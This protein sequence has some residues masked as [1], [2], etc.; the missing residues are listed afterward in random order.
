MKV[1]IRGVCRS[2][3]PV[4]TS[5]NFHVVGMSAPVA[6]R[7][8]GITV[9]LGYMRRLGRVTPMFGTFFDKARFMRL[10]EF[11]RRLIRKTL[12]PLYEDEVMTFV[13]WLASRNS[14]NNKQKVDL[15]AALFSYPYMMHP[16]AFKL[17]QGIFGKAESLP[18][19]D[20]KPVRVICDSNAY[21]KG[22]C[23][24]AVSS[25]EHLVYL[26]DGVVKKTPVIQ[27]AQLMRELSRAEGS[28]NFTDVS[29]YEAHFVAL[30][31]RTFNY[32]RDA[33]MLGNT[34]FAARYL[35]VQREFF[36]KPRKFA[37]RQTMY[38]VR[39]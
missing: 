15:A 38:G 27:R 28:L 22:R 25:M 3:K 36:L 12:R 20:P 5:L 17:I 26:I 4:G 19:G 34:S 21:L 29:C 23:G 39:G 1:A 6:N 31:Q 10:A 35:E 30:V 11:Y 33:Y 37:W 7:Y 2:R 24:P 32:E 8:D 18:Q 9:L 13:G 16:R 14:Y